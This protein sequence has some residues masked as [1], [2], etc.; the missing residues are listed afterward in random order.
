MTLRKLSAT[1]I[2][3]IQTNIKG[4]TDIDSVTSMKPQREKFCEGDIYSLSG[5]ACDGFQMK[6]TFYQIIKKIDTFADTPIQ[7]VIVKQL[8]EPTDIIYTLSKN[9][10]RFLNL[11]YEPGLQ[12]FPQ[13][14]NWKYVEGG[15]KSQKNSVRIGFDGKGKYI[16]IGIRV[17]DVIDKK[18][19]LLS[20]REQILISMENFQGLTFGYKRK[21]KTMAVANGNRHYDNTSYIANGYAFFYDDTKIFTDKILYVKVYLTKDME[22]CL[23]EELYNEQE[24]DIRRF[25]SVYYDDS[26]CLSYLQYKVREQLNKLNSSRMNARSTMNHNVYWGSFIDNAYA[27]D[28]RPTR[29]N[30]KDYFERI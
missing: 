12:L 26:V 28:K 5:T 29:Y 3:P 16:L 18:Y 15:E 24:F 2:Y 10:C 17:Y 7:G 8:S 22:N 14:M 30:I 11:D 21:N 6:E 4:F 1:L 20:T 19:L 23:E 25:L 13:G 27:I 9:D